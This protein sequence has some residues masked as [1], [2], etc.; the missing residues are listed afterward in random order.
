MLGWLGRVMETE[1]GFAEGGAGV[2]T[3]RDDSLFGGDEG[4]SDGDVAPLDFAVAGAFGGPD[5]A[6]G[7]GEGDAE[8]GAFAGAMAGPAGRL[9]AMETTVDF[10]ERGAH[11]EG[12]AEVVA[13]GE[14]EDG[15][16]GQG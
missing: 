2:V 11:A 6:L 8:G 3:E 15:E 14:Q 16:Q 9:G 13:A 7:V 12:E 1:A 10:G 5:F 4:G